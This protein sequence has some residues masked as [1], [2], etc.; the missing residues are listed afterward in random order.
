M[1]ITNSQICLKLLFTLQ[2]VII[3]RSFLLFGIYLLYFIHFLYLALQRD[4]KSLKRRIS[5]VVYL[6][7]ITGL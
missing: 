2:A 6:Y 7:L 3:I 4:Y 5:F 1:Y